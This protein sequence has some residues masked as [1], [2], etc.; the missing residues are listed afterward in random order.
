[1]KKYPIYCF[2]LFT[3]HLTVFS[4]DT[5]KEKWAP[6][7]GGISSNFKNN[8]SGVTTLTVYNNALYAGGSFNIAGHIRCNHIAMWNGS[9]WDSLDN[10]LNNDLLATA[11]FNNELIAAGAFDSANRKTVQYI[12]S[13]NGKAWN[14]LGSGLDNTVTA[15]IPFNGK[16]YAGGLFTQAMV[17]H[18]SH[19]A[20]W[21]GQR[22]AGVGKGIGGP[23]YALCVCKGTLYAAGRFDRVGGIVA[24]NITYWNGKAWKPLGKGLNGTV[25]SLVVF[26]G[27]LYAAGT[28]TAS[29]NE[30]CHY[31]A[32]WNGKKWNSLGDEKTGEGTNLYINGMLADKDYLYIAGSFTKA[33]NTPAKYVAK[34]DGKKW[35]A[36]G[37]SP[38]IGISANSLAL[39]NN[40]LYVGG[41]FLFAT[42]VNEPGIHNVARLVIKN[43]K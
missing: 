12:A 7:G 31:V 6:L 4:Q 16:L 36:V 39:F 30:Q 13:W 9:K 3:S 22:W 29:G 19:I 10:G 15:L 11:V 41:I 37:S 26:K 34:W 1:M 5:L 28:F 38:I 27:Q 8:F 40:E 42:G 43:G 17:K 24:S 2:L 21:D 33:G 18:L 20:C 23:V 32:Y 14:L 25:R 35:T